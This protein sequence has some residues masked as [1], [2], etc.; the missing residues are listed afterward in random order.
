MSQKIKKGTITVK[1]V[2][3]EAMM[4][5][6]HKCPHCKKLIMVAKKQDVKILKEWKKQK[7]I[8]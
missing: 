8:K 6:Y 2:F 1:P 5:M 4:I 7:T 3:A